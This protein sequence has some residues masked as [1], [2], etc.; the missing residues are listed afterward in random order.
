MSYKYQILTFQ[1][2]G[3]LLQVAVLLIL[4]GA[5][6]IGSAVLINQLFPGM[7]TSVDLGNIG[8]SQSSPPGSAVFLS[9]AGLCIIIS[10]TILGTAIFS[11]LAFLYIPIILFCLLIIGLFLESVFATLSVGNLVYD[12]AVFGILF[13]QFIITIFLLKKMFDRF[14]LKNFNTPFQ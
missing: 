3:E 7:A 11:T 13:P 12:V 4:I 6:F 1:E 5:M 14:E 2:R 10:I 9:L 8:I